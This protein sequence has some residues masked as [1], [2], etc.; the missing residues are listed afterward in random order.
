MGDGR[1]RSEAGRVSRYCILTVDSTNP[2]FPEAVL[3]C[4]GLCAK[5]NPGCTVENEGMRP[6]RTFQ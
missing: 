2:G 1:E 6:F 3:E 5:D 4:C